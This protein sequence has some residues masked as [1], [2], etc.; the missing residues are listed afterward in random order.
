M[1]QLK[2]EKMKKSQSPFVFLSV[3]YAREKWHELLPAIKYCLNAHPT[4]R[5]QLEDAYLFFSSHRGSS[6]RIALKYKD[7]DQKKDYKELIKPIIHFLVDNPCD[8]S[9][10]QFPITGFFT[11]F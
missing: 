7:P 4:L 2:S 11:D 5:D 1:N 9:P 3:F 8:P 10:M 6:I